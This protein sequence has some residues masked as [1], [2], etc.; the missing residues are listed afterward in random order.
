MT[1]INYQGISIKGKIEI[2]SSDDL[3]IISGL[4]IK[5]YY[6]QATI[7]LIVAVSMLFLFSA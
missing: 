6:W 7:A 2:D 3:L 1:L 5:N 4:F